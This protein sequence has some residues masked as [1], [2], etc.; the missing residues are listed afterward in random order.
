MT[1]ACEVEKGILKHETQNE[2]AHVL[3]KIVRSYH[4]QTA[5]CEAT[6][7]FSNLTSTTY[8][9]H[10]HQHT[11]TST[12]SY[13]IHTISASAF[14]H[15]RSTMMQ[16]HW[17]DDLKGD[18]GYPSNEKRYGHYALSVE[19]VDAI[20]KIIGRLSDARAAA[21]LHMTPKEF[22]RLDF[23]IRCEARKKCPNRTLTPLLGTDKKT[24]LCKADRRPRYWHYD[25]GSGNAAPIL[26]N[27]VYAIIEINELGRP[28]QTLFN[29]PLLNKAER[30][31]DLSTN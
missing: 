15:I 24:I 25:L 28:Y 6:F 29:K 9:S 13:F 5:L 4:K 22:Q 3:N 14:S 16:D 17:I 23:D 20:Y 30:E 10:T 8:S 11:S 19:G 12:T 21:L 18:D 7:C 2:K 27:I 31:V 26:V 1:D